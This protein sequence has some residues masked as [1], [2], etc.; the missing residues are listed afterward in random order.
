MIT[1]VIVAALGFGTV[2]FAPIVE[3]LVKMFGG[4][5]VAG[6]VGGEPKTFMVLS[7]IILIVC[8]IGSLFM[9]TPPD[10]YT[11]V[12]A[13]VSVNKPVKDK[14]TSQM[15][16][17][18]HFYLAFFTMLLACMGGLMMIGFAKP[19]AVAK[20]LGDIAWLGVMVVALANATGRLLWGMISDKLGRINT[21]IVLLVG[22]SVIS[23][24]VNAVSGYMILGLIAFIGLFYGGFLSNF[25]SLTADLF[26]AKSQ[27][28]NY[29]C[30]LVSFGIGAILSSQIAGH[31]MNAA[32]SAN[33]IS[34]LFPAFVIASCCA[35]AGIVM[36][37]V[38]KAMRK[39]EN[40]NQ[41]VKSE[42]KN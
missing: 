40:I 20:E 7:G 14:T 21:I 39:K 6:Q 11:V 16:R 8:T 18:P 3:S 42:C 24:F 9:K 12:G 29:G 26:G 28:S 32:K 19:I 31:F 10:G 22:T 30:V 5:G 38:L 1:G 35:A 41:Q 36:M 27:G 2:I 23:L 25:P 4:Q 34:R 13:S 17:T 33:D 37:L 15:L